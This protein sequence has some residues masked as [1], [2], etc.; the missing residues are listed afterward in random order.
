MQDE[1]RYE[2]CTKILSLE[3]LKE[4]SGDMGAH[5]RIILK[6]ILNKQAPKACSGF[7]YGPEATSCECGNEH[8]KFILKGVLVY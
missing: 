3:N 8:S 1:R 2:G 4:L 5:T 7:E 6:Q